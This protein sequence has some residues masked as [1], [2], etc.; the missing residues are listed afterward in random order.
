[1]KAVLGRIATAASAACLISAVCLTIY[2]AVSPPV[3]ERFT[4]FYILGPEGKACGY[5]TNL[6]LGETGALIIGIVNHEY[7]NVTYRIVVRLENETIATID[8]I[9]LSHGAKWERVFEFAPQ[10]AGERM[11]LEFLLYREGMEEPYRTLHLWVTVR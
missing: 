2:I 6:S 5:P 11:K 10:R 9:A 7:Q 4:E 3:G 8:G 1:M